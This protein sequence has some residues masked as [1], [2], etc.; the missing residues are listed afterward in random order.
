MSLD[1]MLLQ[2][3]AEW[4]P[5]AGERQTLN[6]SDEASGWAVAVTADR[7]DRL[8]VLLWEVG[9]QRRGPTPEGQ[10]LATWANS[11]P[12]QVTGLLE[13]LHVVEIDTLRNEA[14]L[15]S[16]EPTQRKEKLAYYELIFR[17]THEAVVRRYQGSPHSGR[18]EQV[19]FALTHEVLAKLA[20]DLTALP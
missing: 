17:G 14:L 19:P 1:D 12:G 18:R 7:C 13:S 2:K 11:I 9:L 20:R 6:L 3:L 15:R 10:A 16:E 5:T 8:G 4:C